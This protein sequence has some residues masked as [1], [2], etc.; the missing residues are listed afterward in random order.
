MTEL[1][2]RAENLSGSLYIVRNF[3]VISS[4]ALR[5][6]NFQIITLQW[7]IRQSGEVYFD[8]NFVCD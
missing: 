2:A 3:E 5:P 6:L 7:L 8:G 1:P 4:K